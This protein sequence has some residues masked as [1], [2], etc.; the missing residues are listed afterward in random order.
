[1]FCD[2]LAGS[3]EDGFGE[4]KFEHDLAFIIGH[5]QNRVQKTTLG[6]FGLQQFPDHGP[7][8]LPCAI[9]IPQLFAFRIG[10][11]VVAD[12]GVEKIPWQSEKP[13]SSRARL[14]SRLFSQVIYLELTV[15]AF[16]SAAASGQ[17][18]RP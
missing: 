1:M 4:G 18:R 8:D 2:R 17:R 12:T 13:L 16:Q 11:Q 6:V 7:R 15:L 3:I 14:G 5:F 10:D 9:R